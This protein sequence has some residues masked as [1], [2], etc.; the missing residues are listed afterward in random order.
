MDMVAAKAAEEI[1][2]PWALPEGWAWATLTELAGAEGL[3]TDGDWVESK[4]QD[5]QGGVRL[6]QLADIGDGEFLD[7]SN[8]YLTEKT[9]ERLRCTYLKPGDLL[10]A[11][12]AAPLGRTCL[13][14]GA[15]QPAITVVD[16]CVWRSSHTLV[17]PRWLMHT[18]N[19]LHSRKQIAAGASG[20]TRQRISGGKLK[21]IRIPLAPLAEQKRIIARVDALFAEIAEGEAALAAARKGLDTF[22]RALLKAAVTGELTKDWRDNNPVDETGHDL[23][24]RIAKSRADAPAKRGGR[25]AAEAKAPDASALP[26]L[27]EGWA[28][29]TVDEAGSV[30]LGRQRAPQHHAGENMRPYV[31]VAN[32]FEDR[33]DVSDVKEMNFTPEEFETFKLGDGDVLLNEGQTPDL[34]GR[35]AIWRNQVEDCCFQNTLIRFRAFLGIAPEWA[36]LVFR[37]YLH[38]KRFKRES[39][40]TTNIAHLSA[41]RFS[42]IEFPIPPP[43]EAAEI[44]RRVTE[45]LAA[46]DD[47]LAMLDAEAADAARL[48]QSILKSAFEGR[49]VSQ[50]PADEPAADLLARLAASPTVTRARRERRPKS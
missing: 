38:I 5:P 50:D 37:A 13:F 26:V 28:W 40:I 4:D 2:R 25:R 42:K 15:A 23:L 21:Q 44:L 24:A 36:L 20:T 47:T 9:A 11:R 22:R 34:L 30:Q 31:R 27:P 14:L 10:I 7:R 39:Q 29:G 32:V 18:L 48:K 33:I 8:R 3:M 17:E 6:V 16:V 12:M 45:A 46:N 35:P 49:L 19:C 41:G 43:A 1:D